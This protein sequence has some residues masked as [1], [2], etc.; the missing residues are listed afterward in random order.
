M[1]PPMEMDGGVVLPEADEL[2]DALPDL[3]SRAAQLPRAAAAAVRARA[4]CT[5][6]SGPARCTA[7]CASAASRRTT[8]TSSAR[9]SSSPTSCARCSRSCSRLLRAFGF[10]EFEAQ[11]STRARRSR[12]APTRSGT[13]PPTRCAPRSSAEGLPYDGGRGR[14][15]V[16]RAQDRR[17]RPRRH[18][19]QVAAVDASRSTSTCPT[20][21]SSSTS[22]PT[23]PATAR[24]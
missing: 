22:A 20:A 14:R 21:S 1:Y 2:P 13:R 8:A 23:T 24:S 10:D 18:R 5:A 19:P 9:R 16:L 3:Q 11:L 15:R 17:R 12:S 7:S 4:R 6:T